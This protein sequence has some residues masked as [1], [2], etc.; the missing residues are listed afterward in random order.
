MTGHDVELVL[1]L[2]ELTNAPG[3]KEEFAALWADLE[4]ALTGQ[5]LQR[6]R[7]HSLDGAG[8]TVRLEV[9]RAGAGVVGADTRFAVVA[10]RERAEIRYRCRHC[11]GKAEYAPFLC[12]VCPSDGND[13]RVC[14]RHVVMLDGA[15]IA[16]CQ[17]HRPTCQACPSAAVFRCTGRA[18]Q[19]AKAW[20]GTHRRSHPKDPDLA[21][22]PPCFEEAFPRCESSSCGDLGS[23]RCEHLTR[24]FRRC[25]RRMCTQHAHRWQ[26]FGGERVGL[27]RCSA[28]RAVKSAAPDE[29]LFQIVGGAARRRHKERQPSLSGFG[30]T[31]RYCEHAALAKDLPAVHRMLRALEREVVRNA[32][33]TAAMAESWQ[34]WDRQLKEALED[35]AEGE[36]LIA[37]LRPLVHSRLTQEIQLGEY[38]RASGA[39][40]AL[41]FVE[42]PDDLAG[43]FYGKNR[44]NIA[45]YEK[46]L[47]VT[48]KRERGDR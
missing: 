11:T 19:R 7:V 38:K 34:A 47:G 41:L 43:L 28:H 1:D 35:R 30:Y 39:R 21:F 31:L 5:D 29:V 25:A 33:T 26:V 2:R 17:D 6:R 32:V 45:K 24:D 44:G 40:K 20:C 18:C 16:T 23:V 10:V 8:G 9:V 37:V 36:R 27:G 12:S 13:N 4:I 3:T 42:V 14:D 46:A 15:L 22:C 48:V